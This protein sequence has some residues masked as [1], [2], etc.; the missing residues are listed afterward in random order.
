MRVMSIYLPQV[1][2]IVKVID[3]KG[4]LARFRQ[5]GKVSEVVICRIR[6]DRF[7]RIVGQTEQFVCDGVR[8]SNQFLL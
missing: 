3:I 8:H 1:R 7:N 2:L 5:N 4:Y 6:L